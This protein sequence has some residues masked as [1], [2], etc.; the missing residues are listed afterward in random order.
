MQTCS[1]DGV[2]EL[3]RVDIENDHTPWPETSCGGTDPRQLL[4]VGDYGRG[5]VDRLGMEIETPKEVELQPRALAKAAWG[6]QVSGNS[7]WAGKWPRYAL[8][9]EKPADLLLQ[10]QTY[11]WR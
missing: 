3:W 6:R 9:P 7:K 8:F 10:A 5:K 2:R 1:F 4:A 11:V